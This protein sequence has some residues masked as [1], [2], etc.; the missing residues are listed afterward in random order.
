MKKT[1]LILLSVVLSVA[2]VLSLTACKS[3]CANGHTYTVYTD[4]NDGTHSVKCSVCG[5]ADSSQTNVAHVYDQENNTKCKCGATKSVGSDEHV[6]EHVCDVCHKCQDENCKDPVC[7]AKCECDDIG[8]TPCEHQQLESKAAVKGA[9]CKTRGTVAHYE[10]SKCGKWFTDESAETEIPEGDSRLGEFGDHSFTVYTNNNDDTHTVSC[11][12][13][14]DADPTQTNVAHSYTEADSKCK[15]GA[16]KPEEEHTYEHVAGTTTHNVDGANPVACTFGGSDSNTCDKCGYVY[17][18]DLA[19]SQA[20]G[21]TIVASGTTGRWTSQEIVATVTNSGAAETDVTYTIVGEPAAFS[22]AS[23]IFTATGLGTFTVKATT[24]G[25]TKN[26]NTVE[27]QVEVL[28]YTNAMYLT[29]SI[30]NTTDW[31]T[32]HSDWKLTN[33]GDNKSYSIDDLLMLNGDTFKIVYNGMDSE[34]E[35]A[36]TNG[37]NNFTANESAYYTVKVDISGT[38]PVV[39]IEKTSDYTPPA[40]WTFTFAINIDIIS[41]NGTNNWQDNVYTSENITVDANTPTASFTYNF[42]ASAFSSATSQVEIGFNVNGKWYSNTSSY[43]ITYTENDCLSHTWTNGKWYN[44]HDND[45]SFN[46]SL[47][48][49]GAVSGKSFTFTFTFDSTGTITACEVTSAS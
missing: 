6:C 31:G 38:V 9:D 47:K 13:C 3:A 27:Q 18:E 12:V 44:W 45:S 41:V 28:V 37:G 10:C 48:Y 35:G 42:S 23:G 34:W 20:S 7:S 17:V 2:M 5:T 26:G 32:S 24:V 33:A 25:I 40:D 1:I 49:V 46:D 8:E 21:Y 30:N 29:G 14:G 16:V 4:N 22:Y 19:F 11:A 39:T 15:C 43:G 36:I